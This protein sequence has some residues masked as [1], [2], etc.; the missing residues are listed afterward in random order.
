[1]IRSALWFEWQILSGNCNGAIPAVNYRWFAFDCLFADVTEWLSTV[2]NMVSIASKSEGI[3]SS[4]FD[5]SDMESRAGWLNNTN[6]RCGAHI[7]HHSNRKGIQ[8][9][10]LDAVDSSGK[11]V[12]LST[13]LLDFDWRLIRP[14][15][16]QS[17]SNN[18]WNSD[19]SV[20]YLWMLPTYWLT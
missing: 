15:L 18:Y 19:E 1:M 14:M 17:S 2:A 10:A 3:G 20:S 11:L 12:Y 7:V 8:P 13:C 5:P 9:E 6:D 4:G 16:N